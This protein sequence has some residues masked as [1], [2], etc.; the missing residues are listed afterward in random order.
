MKI[1]KLF[2][3]SVSLDACAGILLMSL[4]AGS[5]CSRTVNAQTLDPDLRPD[6]RR[7]I[8][9]QEE[10]LGRKGRANGYVPEL[11]PGLA[12]V[13]PVASS[14]IRRDGSLLHSMPHPSQSA[15][16]VSAL[17]S[18]SSG[19]PLNRILH[20]SQLSLTSSAGSDEQY[21]D[22]NGD[23][24]A[25]ERTTLDSAGGSF[26]IAVGRS[27]ARYEVYSA[28]L[29]NSLVGVVVVA[30][31]T[32]GDY[33]IDASNTYNLRTDFN[34]PS[35][36]AVVTGTSK[37]G[38]EFVIVSS[39][40]YYNS[41]NPNDPDN[42]LSPGIILLVR[43]PATGGFD[44]AR[45][46]ELVHVGD[47][48]LYN[49]NALALLPNNDLLI[50]DFH[51][52]ELRIIR[53]TDS[54]GIPDTLATA[55][56]YSY[57]F[58][59]D[60][61]L[62]IA[63]NSRGIVFSH[64]AGN[65]TVM[66]A[67]YDDNADGRA[68]RDEVVVEG[69]SLDNN[70][71]LHGLTVDRAGNVYVIEDASGTA[72]ASSSGGNGG[73]PRVDAFPDPALDG[74][75]LDGPVFI[76]ADDER[77]QALT[78]L[79]FGYS[80]T[81]AEVAHLTLVNSAKLQGN[82]TPDGLGSIIGTGLTRGASGATE[83]EAT[84]RGLRVSV[85]GRTVP[86]FSFSDNQVNIY[87]PDEVGNGTRSVV[88]TL[89]SDVIAAD[90]VSV[91]KSNPGIFTV[92]Q[93]GGGEAI[94]LLVSGFRYSKGP[95]PAK[96]DNQRSVIAV[97]GTGWRKDLP[98]SVQIGGRTAVVQYAGASGQFPGLDQINVEIPEGSSGASTIVVTTASGLTSRNDVVV[99][100]R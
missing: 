89:G 43:D 63:V 90:E 20:T 15:A 100:I 72:D 66:L 62:D 3:S 80:N 51:S 48:R 85:D 37:A 77:T 22:R 6:L 32:N 36:A 11:K 53:D 31:D 17:T 82:A 26:D 78:G 9:A 2:V 44:T 46:R 16:I 95:F 59:N 93:N 84:A 28:T 98:A 99:T 39:S 70:L 86:I 67:L 14:S 54:D 69:L 76:S 40:G 41:S 50:A 92:P 65:N 83:S 71:F 68:D 79:S 7:A 12:A 58:S 74:F 38:R 60:A 81:L 91:A 94:A 13:R 27:G 52:D 35:A 19:T 96:T 45:S 5:F 29:N 47:N 42:E 73:K 21:I 56:Y 33:R 1:V 23:L 87:V 55:P 57:R 61:P 64:S 75:L 49:A 88:V 10:P 24:I 34:L 4:L 30:L 25:D 97:F 8:V 18:I